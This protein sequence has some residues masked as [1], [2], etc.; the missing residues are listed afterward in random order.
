[1]LVVKNVNITAN[2]SQEDL[3]RIQ[4]TAAALGPFSLVNYKFNNGALSAPGMQIIAWVCQVMPALPPASDP[5][6]GTG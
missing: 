6:L 4:G 1:M 2:W 5:A 3:A